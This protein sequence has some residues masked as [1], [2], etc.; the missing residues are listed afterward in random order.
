MRTPFILPVRLEFSLV[1]YPKKNGGPDAVYGVTFREI[2]YGYASSAYWNSF[3]P[4][5]SGQVD[6][7]GDEINDSNKVIWAD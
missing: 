1:L 3:N 6:P 2:K 5:T 7:M 4:K